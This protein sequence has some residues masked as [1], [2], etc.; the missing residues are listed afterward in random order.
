MTGLPQTLLRVPSKNDLVQIQKQLID[1]R[2]KLI[3]AIMETV[4]LED[5]TFD[6]VYAPV[7]RYDD[8]SLNE[9]NMNMTL[10]FASP[11]AEVQSEA[12]TAKKQW[13][14]HYT[15]AQ[16]Q[17]KYIQLTMAASEHTDSLDPESKRRLDKR[18]EYLKRLGHGSLDAKT[19]KAYLDTRK[20][21][22][23]LCQEMNRNI[24]LYDGGNL[25]FTDDELEGL[26]QEDVEKYEK[27][28]SGKRLVPLNRTEFTKIITSAS[29][30]KT[31]KTFHDAWTSRLP[32]NVPLFRKLILLRDENARRIGFKSD[33]DLCLAGR[34]AKST[35]WAEE[36][37]QDL[38]IR[39]REPGR[40]VFRASEVI[41][42]RLMK[43]ESESVDV[44]AGTAVQ[45]WELGYLKRIEAKEHK[46]DHQAI[47]TYLPF[48]Q[49]TAAILRNITKYLQLRLEPVAKEDLVG[50]VWSDCVDV[51]A[52]WDE[53][54]ENKGQFVGYFYSD[55]LDRPNKYKHNQTVELQGS[56]LR[57]DGSRQYPAA[58]LMCSFSPAVVDGCKLLKHAN[59]ITMYH[60]LGHALHVLLAR[61][62][63]GDSHGY[64]VCLEFGEGIGTCMEN[65]AWLQ[66][67]LQ[68]ISCHYV[69]TG[70][71]YKQAWMERH[72]DQD[73]P[74]RELPADLISG[75]IHRRARNRITY[76]L[77]Q[78]AD[79]S[80]DMA[81]HDP[82]SHRDLE[83]LDET[84]LY[85]DLEAQSTFTPADRLS[86]PQAAFSHLVSG[87]NSG[88]YAYVWYVTSEHLQPVSHLR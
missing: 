74:P 53:G 49:T 61:T 79:A 66:D 60:E 18:V 21:I 86:Y 41:K 81:V 7:L 32:E 5:A 73:L 22:N 40:E 70:D 2:Q 45:N 67:E 44:N 13:S 54:E 15:W 14:E 26:E 56:F 72:P 50:C 12:E 1:G 43:E 39:L 51:W 76:C 52:V 88:Y 11:D 85:Q 17:E 68:S 38:A 27:H 57:E 6:S 64:R 28:N 83:A 29:N 55:L 9:M 25:S 65:Y 80:F 58:I 8:N 23:N 4:N 82:K 20:E 48:K 31:R 37:L 77:N 10:N 87:Y 62:R 34:M 33:A 69:Y 46:V 78:I 63:W 19:R 24:R 30:F 47:S 36:L 35:E 59:I 16:G 71:S 84:R 75:M 42:A 3:E